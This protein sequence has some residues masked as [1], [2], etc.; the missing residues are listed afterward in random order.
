MPFKTRRQ[1]IAAKDRRFT[2]SEGK[3]SLE[4]IKSDKVD[5]NSLAL[6]RHNE[7]IAT[8]A[9]EILGRE[10]VKIL[11]IFAGIVAAQVALRLT[12]F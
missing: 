11:I 12:L 6:G 8:P 2:F 1:K 10:L 9:D 3:V 5:L 7:Q 4:G